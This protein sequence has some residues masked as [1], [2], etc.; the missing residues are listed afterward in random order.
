MSNYDCK[1]VYQPGKG[2]VVADALSRKSVGTLASLMLTEWRFLEK[3]K[4]QNVQILQQCSRH[5]VASLVVEPT[6]L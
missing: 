3:F 4:D 6:L 5:M 2:N 1:I